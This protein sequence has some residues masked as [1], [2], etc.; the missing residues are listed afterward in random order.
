[1]FLRTDSDIVSIQK[2]EEM[3][4]EILLKKDPVSRVVITKKF[5]T[6]SNLVAFLGGFSKGVAILLFACVFP[7]REVLY[8]RKLINY[9][10]SVCFTDDQIQ[11]AMNIFGSSN[12]NGN[13]K[14][15]KNKEE[16]TLHDEPQLKRTETTK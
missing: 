11:T 9:M 4:L 1:M 13:G 16:I 14:D 3:M 6:L 10:F 8:Y 5:Q 7:V 12:S 15:K 2:D